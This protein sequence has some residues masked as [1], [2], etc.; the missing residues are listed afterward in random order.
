MKK[1]LVS[2]LAI[3][4]LGGFVGSL[5]AQTTDIKPPMNSIVSAQ[6]QLIVDKAPSPL[7]EIQESNIMWKKTVIREI[8]FRQKINQV[9]YYPINR[10]EDWANL[11]TVLYDGIQSGDI[12]AYR[13][14]NNIDDMVTPLTRDDFEKASTKIGDPP[15]I[16]KDG[17][18]VPN[19]IAFKDRILNVTRLRIKEDWYF[20]KKLSQFL[21]RIIAI[22]PIIVEEDGLSQPCWIPYD[23]QTRTVLAQSF[24]FNRNNAA[25]RLTY[26]EILQ[27]R[28]FDSYIVKEE[29]VYDRYINSYAF[30]IDALYESER[31]KNEMFDFEQS[32]WEY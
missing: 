20:D 17:E 4:L 22:S 32:L 30:N 7:P 5:K 15:V 23:E 1:T 28:I 6:Q 31:I 10:T 18:E 2:M 14:E 19:E 12:T 11:V 16:W 3:A 9:F 25:A 8:D 26:D 21:V 13:V 29:N 27:K 24:A